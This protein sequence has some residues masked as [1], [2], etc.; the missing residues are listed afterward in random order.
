MNLVQTTERA[1][2]AA[3]LFDPA[4]FDLISDTISAEDFTDTDHRQL[5]SAVEAA[6]AREKAPDVVTVLNVIAESG[7]G[8]DRLSGLLTTIAAEG[9]SAANAPAYA[10]RIATQ[11]RLR[12]LENACTDGA[13]LA[14]SPESKDPGAVAAEIEQRLFAAMAGKQRGGFVAVEDALRLTVNEIDRKFHH[15]G[16]LAG[17]STGLSDLD[18][19]ISG[20]A[21]GQL[22]I[23]GGRPGM[24]KSGLALSMA[25]AIGKDTAVAFFSL[26]MTVAELTERGI[27]AE[28]RIP[29]GKV[30][31]GRL[32]DE[33]WPLLTTAVEAYMNCALFVDDQGGISAADV[34]SRCRRLARDLARDNRTL[35]LIVIDYLQLM[36]MPASET[37]ALALA[38]TTMALKELAK[39][40]QVPVVALSQLNR[41]IEH[42]S[43]QRPTLAD[44]R[45]S[46]SLEQDADVVLFV[47]RADV[48]GE[49]N[50]QPGT[51][52]LIVAKQRN[53]PTG[54]V[55]AAFL[56]PF[57]DFQNLAYGER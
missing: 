51:A 37:R 25:R 34:R 57:A 23:V 33:E 19:L 22:I 10:Y 56:A 31:T 16:D 7:N 26:E 27:A 36:G 18:K 30:R 1:L 14:R 45:E 6:S 39:E 47:Y 42:R 35:G 24:G 2:L 11:A 50:A 15:G 8:L 55:Q 9:V 17:T 12:R 43:N 13:Q 21:P 4:A 49:A 41:G 38:R 28:G 54:T 53:G 29:I 20:F 3:L 32:T 5:Y 40:L 52:E 44:L 46:G 48:A